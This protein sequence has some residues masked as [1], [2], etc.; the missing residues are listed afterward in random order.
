MPAVDPELSSIIRPENCGEAL[1]STW[2]KS[3]FR[4]LARFQLC[5]LFSVLRLISLACLSVYHR[6]IADG[7]GY[8]LR[9]RGELCCCTIAAPR[10][11]G[12]SITRGVRD[13][14]VV[15]I[16]RDNV[17]IT[18]VY[19]LLQ[20]AHLHVCGSRYTG[21]VVVARSLVAFHLTKAV[22]HRSQAERIHIMLSVLLLLLGALF[23]ASATAILL[24]D[25]K[26]RNVVLQRF[27]IRRR[28]ATGSLTPPRSFSPEKQ[29]LPSN[30]ASSSP[31][32][33]DT[34]PPS[35]RHALADLLSD[36]LQGPGESA[37][38]LSRIPDYTYRL[39]SEEAWDAEKHADH[40]T[41]TG[42]SLREIKRLGDFPDYAALSGIPL[43]CKYEGFDISTAKARPFRP[44][45]WAYHQTMCKTLRYL[46]SVSLHGLLTIS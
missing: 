13:G 21:L 34:F 20:C 23:I 31:D 19:L 15:A 42:F 5:C 1:P 7:A 37:E 33:G 27:D 46:Q 8:W 26:Q 36:A 44:I 29:G 30:K 40:V 2:I 35:R 41:A 10:M 39:P 45:R 14:S 28:R 11:A 12:R 32:F 4:T 18:T 9:W 38:Q 25:G 6:S 17:V 24:F 43:P 3:P 16:A 22:S